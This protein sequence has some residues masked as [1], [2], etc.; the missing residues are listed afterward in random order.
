MEMEHTIPIQSMYGIF[1]H[2]WLILMVNVGI[3]IYI[4]YINYIP[5]MDAMGYS[6]L[7]FGTFW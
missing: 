4:H 6:F 7:I 2:I 1:P 3:Y 5:Y